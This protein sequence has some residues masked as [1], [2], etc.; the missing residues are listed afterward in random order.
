MGAHIKP[1]RFALDGGFYTL[2]EAARLLNMST[3]THLAR[4]LEPTDRAAPAVL[5]QY[6][7]VGPEHEVGF[8]DLMEI[9]FITHFRKYISLQSLRKA[10]ENAR[11]RLKLDHPFAT[12]NIQFE[13][14]R[15]SIFLDTATETGER[16]FLN[17][18]NNQVEIYEAIE[19][20]IAKD[21]SFNAG[22][23]IAERWWPL[24]GACPHVTVDPHKAFGRP[25]IGDNGVPT[26]ALYQLWRAENGDYRKV[27]MWFGVKEGEVKEAV[28]FE[29][30]LAA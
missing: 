29:V 1:H 19:Q 26:E 8:Y 3:W 10:A 6:P 17:L 24:K 23:G 30:R 16:E 7:K 20:I 4:W 11:K 21:I 9:R 12:S 27:A 18:M 28:E 14:D 15:K 5:R 13:S 22:T 2:S 25:V